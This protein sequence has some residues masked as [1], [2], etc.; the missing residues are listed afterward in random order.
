MRAGTL[1]ALSILVL[2]TPTTT[3]LGQP[4]GGTTNMPTVAHQTVGQTPSGATVEQ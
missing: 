4:P 2:L 1:F 3:A